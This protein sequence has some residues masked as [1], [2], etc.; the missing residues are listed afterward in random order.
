M[1]S[2]HSKHALRPSIWFWFFGLNPDVSTSTMS[3][4]RNSSTAVLNAAAVAAAFTGIPIALAYIFRSSVPPMR[5][6][7]SEMSATFLWR[8]MTYR[9]AS[10]AT[11]VVFPT[12][13][14]PTTATTWQPDFERCC[15]SALIL[16]C[17]N[18]F[19]MLEITCP[20]VSNRPPPEYSAFKA[21][22]TS[23][24]ISRLTSWDSKCWKTS[25][26]KLSLP[27]PV[28]LTGFWGRLRP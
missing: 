6:E 19:E 14:G 7:S 18:I 20:V 26:S 24:A 17:F 10:L 2:T 13:V 5:S 25:A 9:A 16:F 27:D 23:L 3:N 12:P 28:V 21:S 1:A 11:V 15:V 8:A 22:T 4:F